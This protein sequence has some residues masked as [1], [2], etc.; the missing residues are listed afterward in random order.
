MKQTNNGFT[1]IEVLIASTII[2]IVVF[3]IYSTF[4]SISQSIEKNRVR[5]EMYQEAKAILNRMQKEISS[6]FNSRINVDI[7]FKGEDG[8]QGENNNDALSFVCTLNPL[9]SEAKESDLMKIGYYI[10]FG[11]STKYGT[12]IHRSSGTIDEKIDEG[13]YEQILSSN[14]KDLN[15]TYYDG[16]EWKKSWDTNEKGKLPQLVE[17][18]FILFD[19]INNAEYNFS[20]EIDL[21]LYEV[22][23]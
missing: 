6:A 13:G 8:M 20:T 21:P 3:I 7:R 16:N 15:F 10:K 19:P 5:I 12:L 22:N 23:K 14:I 11:E 17:I 1:L 2:G 4:N 9:K 18:S